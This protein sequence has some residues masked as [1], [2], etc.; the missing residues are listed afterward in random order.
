MH[1]RT[2]P[3]P[4]SYR[5]SDSD[6]PESGV[7]AVQQ[8]VESLAQAIRNKNLEHVMW[9]YAP[10]VIVYDV[11]APLDVRGI[12]AYRKKFERWFA[13][14]A[15]RIHYDMLDVEVSAGE[16]QGIVHCLCHITGARTGGGRLDYW[17]RV[18]SGWKK[19]DGQW[20]ITH[21]HV[22]MPTLI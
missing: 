5:P 14:V 2:E 20:V 16:Q 22:S 12:G 18:T 10:D 1:P 21:E 6:A 11:T 19:I 15:G 9:H 4:S 7:L 13:A 17:V 3:R 8:R